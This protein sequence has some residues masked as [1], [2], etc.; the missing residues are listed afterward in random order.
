LGSNLY[1]NFVGRYRHVSG[2]HD[3]RA[4]QLRASVTPSRTMP[5]SAALLPQTARKVDSILVHTGVYKPSEKNKQRHSYCHRDFL[6]AADLVLPMYEMTDCL[7]AI[8]LI[9]EQNNFH[10]SEVKSTGAK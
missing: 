6:G 5:S 8:R 3:G 9:L 7:E 2:D 1:N 4:H 10:P